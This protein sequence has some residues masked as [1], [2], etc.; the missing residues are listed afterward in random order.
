MI[1][2]YLTAYF[3]WQFVCLIFKIWKYFYEILLY[4]NVLSR[5][6]NYYFKIVGERIISKYIDLFFEKNVTF[7][8]INY[9]K[10]LNLI[11]SIIIN[12][13]INTYK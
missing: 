2:D 13:Y 11:S 8:L 3:F 1:L 6:S 7:K 10:L 9:Y 12:C 4:L 5:Y